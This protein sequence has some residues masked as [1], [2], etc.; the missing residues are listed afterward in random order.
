MALNF[1]NPATQTPVNTFSPTSTPSATTNGVTYTWDGTVWQS[2]GVA[3]TFVEKAGDTMTGPLVLNADPVAALGAA[4]KQYVDNVTP[5]T[6]WT[7]T[8]TTI[9]PT[10]A[11]DDVTTTGDVSAANVVATSDVQ[12]ASLN[13]GPLAGMRNQLINGNLSQWQRS[14]NKTDPGSGYFTAD[15][16]YAHS[17]GNSTQYLR[18][19]AAAQIPDAPCP[20]AMRCLPPGGSGTFI[21]QCIEITQ[22]SNSQFTP[23]SV[24]TLSWYSNRSGNVA[25]QPISVEAAF[26]NEAT[27]ATDAVAHTVGAITNIGGNRYSC[28]ITI[29]NTPANANNT[30]LRI[31]FNN[32]VAADY[33]WTGAQLEPGPVATPFEHRPIGTELAL[34][35]RYFQSF[36]ENIVACITRNDNGTHGVKRVMQLRPVPMR[37]SPTEAAS[38]LSGALTLQGNANY[39]DATTAAGASLN[40]NTALGGYTADA[41]L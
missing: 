11:G 13:S 31:D 2:S 10:V 25:A 41:E 40:T 17:N 37:T 6:N 16:W 33:Q 29:S 36:P 34:C 26:Q 20:F 24:W 38:V 27:G 32:P 18:V 1:P 14:T 3:S 28:Q 19:D 5:A 23:G 4:T 21:R 15:R 9:S 22:G 12:A 35:Q 30:C 8:S 7:R 39:I